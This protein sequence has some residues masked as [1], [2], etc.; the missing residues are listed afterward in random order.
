MQGD[1]AADRPGE[2]E[3]TL[4]RGLALGGVF[5]VGVLLYLIVVVGGMETLV[6]REAGVE[7][8]DAARSLLARLVAPLA[9]WFQAR[10]VGIPDRSSRI[11][12]GVSAF[13]ASLLIAEALFRLV[14]A[15]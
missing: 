12:L 4:G 6:A 14:Q 7:A 2:P 11:L 8:G 10:Y 13:C 1:I 3:M 15:L 9:I 5:L